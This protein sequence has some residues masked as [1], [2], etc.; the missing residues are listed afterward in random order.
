MHLFNEREPFFKQSPR[1]LFLNVGQKEPDLG[2]A[3]DFMQHCECHRECNWP[4]C[5]ALLSLWAK[6][7]EGVAVP[8]LRDT[9]WALVIHA[10][11]TAGLHYLLHLL[12]LKPCV[13]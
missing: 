8:E 7:S 2:Q 13:I 12:A 6:L 11:C 9:V 1:N 5:V 4:H 10:K 3:V